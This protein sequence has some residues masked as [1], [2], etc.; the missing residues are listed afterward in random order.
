MKATII[1]LDLVEFGWSHPRLAED[2]MEA[3]I[4]PLDS[5]TSVELVFANID[6]D[7]NLEGSRGVRLR[8]NQTRYRLTSVE[9]V[10][11]DVEFD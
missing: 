6:F 9:L 3:T 10:F 5:A 8:Q 1:P 7:L 2:A 4:I 11:T